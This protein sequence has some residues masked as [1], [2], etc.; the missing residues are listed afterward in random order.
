MRVGFAPFFPTIARCFVGTPKVPTVVVASTIVLAAFRKGPRIPRVHADVPFYFFAPPLAVVALSVVATP[1]PS[2]SIS[3]T[4]SQEQRKTAPCWWWAFSFAWGGGFLPQ[5]RAAIFG[6]ALVVHVHSD[7]DGPASSHDT[8]FLTLARS[9]PTGGSPS[10]VPRSTFSFVSLFLSSCGPYALAAAV[11]FLPPHA[12]GWRPPQSM[13]P[14]ENSLHRNT[15]ERAVSGG[16]GRL[17]SSL[18]V[19]DVVLPFHVFGFWCFHGAWTFL[20][21]WCHAPFGVFFAGVPPL[22]RVVFAPPS[23][24][25]APTVLAPPP[26][27]SF[28]VAGARSSRPSAPLDA[29]VL[30]VAFPVDAAHDA[31]PPLHAVAV[32]ESDGPACLPDTS[33]RCVPKGR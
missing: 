27:A 19:V 33:S 6:F 5:R 16:G 26:A 23:P 9:T 20:V 31:T 2:L 25:D 14:S 7:D 24:V 12:C 8:V 21:G 22:A 32:P 11:A 18:V 4:P 30:R 13:M 15:T 1:Q 28:A 29:D 3:P 10:P 17:W